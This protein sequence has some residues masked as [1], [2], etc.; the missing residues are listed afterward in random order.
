MRIGILANRESWYF[1]D[2]QRAAAAVAAIKEVVELSFTSLSAALTPTPTFASRECADLCPFDVVLVRTMPA[3]SLEQI[4]FRMNVL[5]RIAQHQTRVVNSPRCLEMAIDK[6]L[7]LAELQAAGLPVPRTYT[8]QTWERAMVDFES[9]GCDV[10]VKP[11][12]G[13]E[14]RGIVRVTDEDHAWRLFKS[15]TQLGQVIYQ[16]EYIEHGGADVRLL[17]IDGQLHAIRRGNQRD[18]R[19]NVQRGARAEPTQASPEMRA[20]AATAVAAMNAHMLAVDFLTDPQGRTYVVEVNAVP[21]WRALSRTLEIDIAKQV[22]M[23][24]IN[25]QAH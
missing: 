8:S 22:V 15:L 3:G 5:H 18:W 19:T 14:G 6:Y 23:S 1:R 25:S 11:I 10:V 24:L 2:L 20:M 4:V 9:L 16:Q 12:F 7:A 17:S 21:G 13:S